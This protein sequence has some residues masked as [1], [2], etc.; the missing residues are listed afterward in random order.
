MPQ[1][2]VLLVEDD[3]DIREL[4]RLYLQKERFR[5]MEAGN[6]QDAIRLVEQEHP[7][8]MILDILLPDVDGLTVCRE[9][10]K[11]SDLPIIFLSCKMEAQDVIHGLEI[12]ADDYVTK[13]FDPSILVTRVK[14]NLRRYSTQSDAQPKE[15]SSELPFAKEQPLLLEPLTK[16]EIEVISLIE[17]GFT[18]QEIAAHFHISLGT[19]KGYNNQLYAKLKVRNRTQAILRARQLGLLTPSKK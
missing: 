15:N 11:Q 17:K 2:K 14:A 8:V 12:G 13:P 19:V 4:V 3:P 1:Q 16:R 18:N 9:V 5:V 7:N 6:G 10:R